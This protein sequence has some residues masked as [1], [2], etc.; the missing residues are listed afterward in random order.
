MFGISAY[1]GVHRSPSVIAP[2]C[3]VSDVIDHLQILG[4]EVGPHA[5]P[6]AGAVLQEV[7]AGSDIVHGIEAL[8]VTWFGEPE[9]REEVW[10]GCAECLVAV[11]NHPMSLHHM[12]EKLCQPQYT[13][14]A[15][16]EL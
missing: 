4:H 5:A 8:Q 13:V 14:R 7:V 3:V 15:G 11:L 9:G 10:Q 6:Y 16:P 1:P 12:M 2:P